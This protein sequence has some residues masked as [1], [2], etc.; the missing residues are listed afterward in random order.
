[1]SYLN[2]SGS[3]WFIWLLPK[4]K[5]SLKFSKKSNAPFLI[6]LILFEF[7]FNFFKEEERP[8][9]FSLLLLL[10]WNQHFHPFLKK[11]WG[12]QNVVSSSPLE[13][14]QAW[15]RTQR[16]GQERLDKA[17]CYQK[18]SN[19]FA[20]EVLHLLRLALGSNSLGSSSARAWKS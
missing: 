20:T 2:E 1:M 15:A 8:K 16:P 7:K 6:T 3:I 4:F 9:I 18:G 19:H 13:V 14:E 12:G 5:K 11:T 17:S 10:V